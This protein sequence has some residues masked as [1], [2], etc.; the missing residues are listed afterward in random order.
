V[1]S[2]QYWFI[3]CG[4]LSHHKGYVL[5]AIPARSERDRSEVTMFGRHAAKSH[6]VDLR[7]CHS[8]VSDD[9]SHRYQHDSVLLG[10]LGELRPSSHGPVIISNLSENAGGT[11]SGQSAEIDS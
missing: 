1:H 8:T 7:F 5:D 3:P 2:H 11:K 10:E 9:I 4:D 6:P